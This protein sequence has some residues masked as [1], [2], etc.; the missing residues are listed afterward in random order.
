[1]GYGYYQQCP[2]VTPHQMAAVSAGHLSSMAANAAVH[3]HAGGTSANSSVAGEDNSSPGGESGTSSALRRS[4][5][6]STVSSNTANSTPLVYSSA[7]QHSSGGNH[8]GI[9]PSSS[10]ANL[11]T[12]TAIPAPP[13]LTAVQDGLSSDCSDDESS[14]PQ[15]SGGNGQ[16]P[17]VYPWMKKIHVA[18]AGTNFSSKRPCLQIFSLIIAACSALFLINGYHFRQR[19]LPTWHGA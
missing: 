5:E 6:S 2:S 13:Q 9:D 8:T 11:G 16:I 7:Q 15:G 17:V 19:N 14:S 4:P 12:P 1:M 10:T 3:L 18:G